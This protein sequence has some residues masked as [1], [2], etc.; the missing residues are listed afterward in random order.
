MQVLL[1]HALGA[2]VMSTDLAEGLEVDAINGE[3]VTVSLDPPSINGANILVDSVVDVEA[4]NGVIHGIASVLTP[5][6]ISNDIVDIGMASDEHA[7]L[8]EAVTAAGLVDALKGDGPLTLFAPTDDAFAALPEGTLE[9]LLLPENVDTLKGILL[10]HVVEGNVHSAGLEST[11]VESLGGT[12]L[13]V[14]VSDDGVTVGGAK[15]TEANV[16]AK[17]GIIHVVDSVIL[18]SEEGAEED[19]EEGAEDEAEEI[20]PPGPT[21]TIAE[22]A[23]SNDEFLMLGRAVT[24]AGL[25]QALA[26]DGPF[27]L[28]GKSVHNSLHVVSVLETSLSPVPSTQPQPPAP[29]P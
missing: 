24:A 16:I 22:I 3:A 25:A 15:V 9:S 8:V 6:S 13:E 11:T 28:F 19:A 26:G 14:V 17:N 7:T 4:S 18:P 10:H 20:P 12:D 2:K 1:Y 5:G 29:T 21:M 27:T 23:T